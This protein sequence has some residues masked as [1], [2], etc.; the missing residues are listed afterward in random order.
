SAWIAR[1]ASSG[2][3]STNRIST[4]L[5]IIIFNRNCKVKSRSISR[6][7]LAPYA[8]AMTRNNPLHDR[9]ADA[10]SNKILNFVQPLKDAEQFGCILHI[11][12]HAIVFYLVTN[13]R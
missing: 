3:S 4:E 5:C 10:R 2:L 1:P 9:K 8:P 6:R 11:E 13:L 7:S 12:A